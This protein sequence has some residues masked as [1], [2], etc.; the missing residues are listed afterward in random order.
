[1][2]EQKRYRSKEFIKFKR[3][4]VNALS[5]HQL[6]ICDRMTDSDRLNI[7]MPTGTGKSRIIYSDMINY[8]E[9]LE[10]DVFVLASHRLM[11]NTQHFSEIFENLSIIAGTIGFIFVGS[12]KIDME[13]FIKDTTF[14]NRL[15]DRGL[16]VKDLC[17]TTT[18]NLEIKQLVYEHK[19]ADRDIII[20]STYHS[21]N[22][23][24]D[25]DIHTLYCD[26]AHLLATPKNSAMFKNNFEVIDKNVKRAYFLTATPK[27]LIDS[28]LEE[29]FL[30]NNTEIFGERVGLT[31]KES[32]EAGYIVR[33]ILHVC[34]PTNYV[35]D[36]DFKQPENY[37]DFILDSY[38]EHSDWLNKKSYDSSQIKAKLMVKCPSVPDI[39]KIYNILIDLKNSGDERLK[40]VNLFAGFSDNEKVSSTENHFINNEKTRDRNEFLSKMQAMKFTEKAIILHFDILSEGINVPGIT[41]VMFL[42]D[43]LPSLSKLLQNIGRSTRLHDFDR[44][45]LS[46]NELVVNNLE[47][48]IKPY[49]SVIVPFTS[50]NSPKMKHDI[51][52]KLKELRD[53]FNMQIEYVVKGEDVSDV[54]K[55]EPD[56]DK[57][58]KTDK[59]K[60]SAIEDIEHAIEELD[61]ID[62]EDDELEELRSK[63]N[64]DPDNIMDILLNSIKV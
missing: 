38:I 2:S 26:E 29:S 10:K 8:L 47:D 52:T 5:A 53:T 14:N 64:E 32:V 39:F 50:V 21:L 37:T 31:F 49:C 19:K 1:M 23:L 11:L 24:K 59:K 40:D 33:P 36:I 55:D 45:R 41:G 34:T 63:V 13:K 57:N 44:L 43:N 56:S 62:R 9:D 3:N 58:K 42:S 28:E 51:A 27:D 7:S 35:N 60:I 46:K 22:R 15:K 6:E 16:N 30:M 4:Y 17:H 48:W 25:V 20:I 18:S 54:E 61:K 12:D